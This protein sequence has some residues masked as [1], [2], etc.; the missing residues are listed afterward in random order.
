MKPVRLV[1]AAAPLALA[2]LIA[3]VLALAGGNGNKQQSP[4]GAEQL[5]RHGY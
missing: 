1:L 4:S 5:A 2:A 3:V